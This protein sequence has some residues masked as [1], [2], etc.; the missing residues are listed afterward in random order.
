MSLISLLARQRRWTFVRV[1][2][3][4]WRVLWKPSQRRGRR[5]AIGAEFLVASFTHT[6]STCELFG[7][8]TC[9]LL[10]IP[11]KSFR[12]TQVDSIW[13]TKAPPFHLISPL[14][15]V[16]LASNQHPKTHRT[17][18]FAPPDGPRP[19]REV[20][21][22][23]SL[24][25]PN[26]RLWIV[27]VV[28]LFVGSEHGGFLNGASFWQLTSSVHSQDLGLVISRTGLR[29]DLVISMRFFEDFAVLCL[30]PP[31]DLWYG[32]FWK[33]MFFFWWRCAGQIE[34]FGDGHP[35]VGLID[36]N[37]V[38]N[39]RSFSGKLRTQGR[40]FEIG[41]TR[42]CLCFHLFFL[43]FFEKLAIFTGVKPQTWIAWG[44][45]YVC[46]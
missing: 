39:V 25:A 28:F 46:N 29:W 17:M 34:R 24:K 31:G 40:N 8:S 3:D 9:W 4:V 42:R 14:F 10:S 33:L 19:C 12:G 43:R 1:H 37:D 13:A 20:S 35:A 44:H 45:W 5:E 2:V 41:P 32:I 27:R 26:M 18:I 36:P 30:C 23:W 16:E 15:A 6:F 21:V 11:S 22:A 7:Q 38:R